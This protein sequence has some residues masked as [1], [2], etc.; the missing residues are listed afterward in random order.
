L[1]KGEHEQDESEEDVE[2]DGELPNGIECAELVCNDKA[3]QGACFGE[4]G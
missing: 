3:E 2:R 1:R 4:T